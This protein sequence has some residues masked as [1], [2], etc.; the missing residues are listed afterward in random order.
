VPDA[1]ASRCP[2]LRVATA[3]DQAEVTLHCTGKPFV[4]SLVPQGGSRPAFTV[5]IPASAI[6]CSRGTPLQL[7]LGPAAQ[8]T[9]AALKV[10]TSGKTSV[11]GSGTNTNTGTGTATTGTTK[12]GGGGTVRRV[13]RFSLA[14]SGTPNELGPHRVSSIA[15]DLRSVVRDQRSDGDGDTR[16]GTLR[17]PLFPRAT[18]TTANGTGTGNNAS[19]VDTSSPLASV[20][21]LSFL[22]LPNNASA[23]VNLINGG[24]AE[25]CFDA[26]ETLSSAALASAEGFV[27]CFLGGGFVFLFR[28]L[29][30]WFFSFVVMYSDSANPPPSPRQVRRRRALR[31][32]STGPGHASVRARLC[33][34]LAGTIRPCAALWVTFR[35]GP[36][37][38]SA[39]AR[40]T[41]AECATAAAG[42]AHADR[43]SSRR[44]R[45]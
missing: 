1:E 32:R 24:G 40:S 21:D 36:S 3:L 28:V 22:A 45:S 6:D 11:S 29:F 8:S 16:I 15:E 31:L 37:P 26:D 2:K 20:I 27:I 35:P 7:A 41:A 14:G 12:P 4:L 25:L 30:F 43:A 33:T 42:L 39:T 23:E 10:K 5:R 44:C 18:N 19:L 13:E 38:P 9:I 17:A 34:R